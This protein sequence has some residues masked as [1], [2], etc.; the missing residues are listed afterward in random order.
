MTDLAQLKQW[1]ELLCALAAAPQREFRS[2][3]LLLRVLER[4]VTN[5]GAVW[6]V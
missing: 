1:V 3:G 5:C 2:I 4:I 6:R